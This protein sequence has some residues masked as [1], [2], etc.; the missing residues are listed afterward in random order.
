[1]L[2]RFLGTIFGIVTF[3]IFP[4]DTSTKDENTHEVCYGQQAGDTQPGAG[5][6]TLEEKEVS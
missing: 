5:F 6:I 2:L 1:M 3:N 4:K